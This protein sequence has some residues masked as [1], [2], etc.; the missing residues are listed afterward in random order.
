LKIFT[1][2]KFNQKQI[3]SKEQDGLYT[4]EFLPRPS[5]VEISKTDFYQK[6]TK[7][8]R[9]SQKI[10]LISINTKWYTKNQISN[11]TPALVPFRVKLH[12]TLNPTC[13]QHL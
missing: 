11:Q 13:A 5:T 9:S 12:E 7:N 2:T 1:K 10:T 8:L 4:G 6:N 3:R